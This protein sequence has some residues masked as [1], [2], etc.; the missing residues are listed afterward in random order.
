MDVPGKKP[1]AVSA[2]IEYGVTVHLQG[3]PSAEGAASLLAR[4]I[5]A[6]RIVEHGEG[7]DLAQGPGQGSTQGSAVDAMVDKLEGE[8]TAGVLRVEAMTGKDVRGHLITEDLHALVRSLKEDSR[9]GLA[10]DASAAQRDIWLETEK[11]R[12]ASFQA[13]WKEYPALTHNRDMFVDFLGKNNMSST[14]P[15]GPA[16]LDAERS[17][18][19]ALRSEYPTEEWAQRARALRESYVSE[20]NELVKNGLSTN[21]ALRTLLPRT[22]PCPAAA[23][24]TTGNSSPRFASNPQSLED[25]WPAASKRLGEE[26]TVIAQIQ[27]SPAGCVTAMSIAGSSG[28]SFLDDAVLKYLEFAEFVPAGS[29]G[30]PV[31]SQV[32][33][34]IVFKLHD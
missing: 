16:V 17:L 34:P 15:H 29:N 6:T 13:Y 31:G 5:G 2:D 7:E 28:S 4:V 10:A 8:A 9:R 21:R 26:G 3:R 14:T 12:L 20:R 32:S 23:K 30:Q 27:I 25:F 33:M 19:A 1:G 18:L 11:Q 22:S 24:T